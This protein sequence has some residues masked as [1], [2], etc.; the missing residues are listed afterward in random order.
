MGDHY[1]Q[2]YPWA[3]WMA[4]SLKKF[5]WPFWTPL[6][7]CGFPMTAES[8]IGTFYLPNLLLYFFL[9]LRVA[10]SYTNVVHFLLSGFGTYLYARH[11]RLEPLP[12]FVAAFIFL[13]GTGYGGAYYNL[14]SL[15][16]ISW[17]PL[18][19]FLFEK[20]LESRKWRYGL[21]LSVSLA[22][23]F[24][25]G[26]LQVAISSLGIFLL[27]GFLRILFFR[28]EVKPSLRRRSAEILTLFIATGL[29]LILS[30]PQ[31]YLTFQLALLSNRAG[32]S[33]GYAYVGSMS[34]F[35]LA[36]LV[37][38]QIQSFF[39]GNCLYGGMFSILLI[40]FAL[41]SKKARAGTLFRLWCLMAAVS[42]LLALGQWSPLY[43]GLIKLTRFY[44]FRTPMKFLIFICFSL[45]LL[46]GIGFQEAWKW[47]EDTKPNPLLKK[48]SRSFYLFIALLLGTFVF[49]FVQGKLRNPAQKKTRLSREVVDASHDQRVEKFTLTG[50][51]DKGQKF[52]NLQG[53]SAKIDAGQTVYLDENV[54]LRLRDN[55][56]IRTDHVQWSQDRGTMRTNAPVF[57][58]HATVKVKGIGAVGRPSDGFIQLNHDVEMTTRQGSVLTCDGPMKIFYN[59]NKMVLY[60]N[61][62]VVD[63]RG[64]LLARRMEVLFDSNEKKV[65]K[66]IAQGD[67]VIQRGSD[68][69]RSRRAIYT[70]SNG[71]IRLEGNP[72]VTV[73]K[74]GTA[75]ARYGFNQ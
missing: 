30:L 48:I 4:Q 45:A 35:V 60:R 15:K 58:D 63:Q 73:Q 21:G 47:A 3:F 13:F 68:T 39:R 66:I 16:T 20:F 42:F 27:Y 59:Q 64:T 28:H 19:L 40:L 17:F 56:L 9:P 8:Q 52:W 5:E 41:H 75:L 74:A 36:T 44:S 51:D 34:P 24:L 12:A 31:I 37:L 38:P 22:M 55:T 67:V 18:S 49:F 1:E 61:V 62:K 10:Y 11:M 33:E 54:T 53:Q 46:S 23:S 65:K 72:E 25:A 57:V 71:S 6:I 14:T 7:H 29:A 69:T 2:H 32:L 26:Y 50:F 43:V 70:V